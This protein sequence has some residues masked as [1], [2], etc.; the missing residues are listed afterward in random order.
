MI[1]DSLAEDNFHD[2]KFY[3]ELIEILDISQTL[4]PE[5]L[6]NLLASGHTEIDDIISELEKKEI[7][8][9]NPTKQW[10]RNKIVFKLELKDPNFR[11][12]N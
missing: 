2:S 4:S 7:M 11:I 8:R 9:E 5:Y 12:L 10:E 6:Y 1:I 3:V